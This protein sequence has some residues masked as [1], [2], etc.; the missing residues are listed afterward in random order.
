MALPTDPRSINNILAT[1]LDAQLS[2]ITD[3]FFN[4][5]ALF[6]K[7][8]LQYKAG[9]NTIKYRGGAEIRS[10]I[11]YAGLPAYMYE[12]GTTFDTSQTEFLTSLQFQ[13]RRAAALLN[14]DHLDVRKNM[15]DESQIIDYVAAVAQNGVNSVYNMIGYRIYGTQPNATTGVTEANPAPTIDPITGAASIDGLY[16]GIATT[17][18]YGGITLGGN[19]GTPGFSVT[20]NIVNAGGAPFSL[21][22]AQ[23]A[24][25]LATFAQDQPDLIVTTQK[26]FNA[27]WQRAQ[28]QDR[29]AP[30][31]LRD[32]GFRT[33]KFNQAEVIVDS[34]CLP[35][36]M[37]FLDTKYIEVWIMDGC[38]FVR[39]SGE[40][41]G[42]PVPTQDA[43]VDQLIAYLDLII[44][45][46][47]YQSK[48]TNLAE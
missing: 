21:D 8:F 24:Y 45:G 1:T 14:L 6:Q 47:R 3:N 7:L 2:E 48:L 16:N 46:P 18:S 33:V 39:R 15:G 40:P 23:E 27:F 28:P 31:P 13:W 34:H 30:G 32:V 41:L 38:D 36:D 44:P 4:T 22:I 25:G 29:N 42:F 12:K 37:Y 9:F 19:F 26:Q 20:S 35:G 5:N 10:A 43:F 11:Q 17:G